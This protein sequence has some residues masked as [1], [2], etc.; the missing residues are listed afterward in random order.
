MGIREQRKKLQRSI[1][2]IVQCEKADA[3]IHELKLLKQTLDSQIDVL[4]R[5]VWP[6]A[7]VQ[8]V[9]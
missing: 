7:T 5:R 9:E 3:A 2:T 1:I 6:D 8:S 4:E